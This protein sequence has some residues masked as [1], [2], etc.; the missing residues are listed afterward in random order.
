[1]VP[2]YQWYAIASMRQNPELYNSKLST[3]LLRSV[4]NYADVLIDN[5]FESHCYSCDSCKCPDQDF[6]APL[7]MLDQTLAGAATGSC[8]VA[9]PAEV[10]R[11]NRSSKTSMFGR[12]HTLRNC[13]TTSL[14]LSKRADCHS[15]GQQLSKATVNNGSACPVL[16]S[17][18]AASSSS[19]TASSS[20]HTASR[21]A[22]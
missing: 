19:H 8:F 3:H 1:M 14:L 10:Q 17:N 6:P 9:E 5:E 12:Y 7:Y 4:L 20:S 2:T 21:T 15:A 16:Q 22:S 13:C 11:G 18:L